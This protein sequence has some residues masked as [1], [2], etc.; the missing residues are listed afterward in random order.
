MTAGA[1]TGWLGLLLLAVAVVVLGWCLY[2]LDPRAL[3]SVARQASPTWLALS[4]GAVL[5]RF[6]IWGLKWQRMLARRAAVPFLIV[7]RAI[8]AGSFA[9]LVTPTF[10]LAGGVVRAAVVSRR[11]GWAMLDAWGY[12]VADQGT[13]AVG[14]L[15]LYGVVALAAAP[16]L[17]PG[18]MRAGLALSGLLVLVTLVGCVVVRRP[19]WAWAL[20]PAPNRMVAKILRRDPPRRDEEPY[21]ARVLRPLVGPGISRRDWVQDIGLA[22]TSITAVCIANVLVLRALGVDAPFAVVASAVLLSYLAGTVAGIGGGLGVTEA[23]LATI[24]GQVG[25]APST[26]AAGVL[27]HRGMFYVIVLGAGGL[28]FAAEGRNYLRRSPPGRPVG[29][30]ASNGDSPRL[31]TP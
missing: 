13:N 6:L 9:N 23:A 27:L 3:W 12:A 5:A 19:I 8:L 2:A 28:A 30:S 17:A 18:A 11:C 26:A 20:R 1:R 15:V 10:K 22:A 25:M 16:H 31:S 14:H 21:L 29:P 7:L 4:A 24:Y